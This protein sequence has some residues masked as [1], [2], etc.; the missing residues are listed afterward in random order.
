MCC[1]TPQLVQQT[2]C[3]TSALPSVTDNVGR[4]PD[5]N[6]AWMCN[7]TTRTEER[8][9]DRSSSGSRDSPNVLDLNGLRQ[10]GTDSSKP[11]T[12]EN[13][14]KGGRSRNALMQLQPRQRLRRSPLFASCTCSFVHCIDTAIPVKSLVAQFSENLQELCSCESFLGGDR[15][16]ILKCKK[17]KYGSQTVI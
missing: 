17:T 12:D 5:V 1:E 9:V 6:D 7:C 13:R 15:R 8:C 14:T 4:H 11:P 2:C 10:F 16:L 3:K